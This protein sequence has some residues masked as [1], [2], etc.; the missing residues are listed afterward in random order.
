MGGMVNV[1]GCDIDDLQQL[2]DD[3]RDA[4]CIIAFH[5]LIFDHANRMD[6]LVH[7]CA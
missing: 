4:G 1:F 3:F 6:A 5:Y 2:L 7:F